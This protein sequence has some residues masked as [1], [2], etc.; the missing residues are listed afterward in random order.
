MGALVKDRDHSIKEIQKVFVITLC[1][2]I[3]QSVLYV[4]EYCS[5]MDL[6]H[7]EKL[8]GTYEF[9]PDFMGNLFLSVFGG[10]IGG[11]ILVSKRPVP[12][13]Q[14]SYA[15]DV[16]GSG[17]LF[18]ICYLPIATIGLS[19][20]RFIYF[21]LQYNIDSAFNNSVHNLMADI[22]TPS[23]FVT[24]AV[25]G[26]LVSATQ[27]VLHIND[28]FGQG[29]LW[30]V[31]TGKYHRPREEER[32]F[33]FLD[34]KGATSIAEKMESNK[35]FGMLSEVYRDITG[36]IVKSSGE[37]YQYVGDEVVISWPVDKG[38]RDNNALQ[39]FFRIERKMA[40]QKSK[41]INKYG[42]VPAFKAGLH[43]GKATTGEIGVIKKEIVY[44]GD[45]LNTTSRIQALCNHH[46]VKILISSALL[47]LM[48]LSAKYIPIP[49]GEIGL[50][51]KDQKISLNTIQA[52]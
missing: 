30:K 7:M 21:M 2:A 37:I 46:N 4:Q 40:E 41:Y 38:I 1:W 35:F 20:T 36:P 15:F 5:T 31:I 10:A 34:L 26:L 39:C 24:M 28:K 52:I 44:S 8:T 51:G 29:V 47:Q 45:V 12:G 14:K 27:F 17:L 48:K 43:I 16:I 18:V 50:R 49:M 3:V 33:M 25:W 32:I 6:I 13:F 19:M 9:W 23:F 42:V 22:G 11:T